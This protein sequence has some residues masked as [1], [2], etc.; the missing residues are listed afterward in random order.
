MPCWDPYAR[1]GGAGYF[2]VDPDTFAPVELDGRFG[3]IAPPGR[4]PEPV[5]RSLTRYLTFE[6]LPRTP[7]N[8]ALTNIHAPH[9]NAVGP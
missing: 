7:A 1:C 6:Y 9:P 3:G 8:L 2:Y 5:T 4:R